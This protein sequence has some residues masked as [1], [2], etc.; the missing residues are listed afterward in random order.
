MPSITLNLPAAL[1]LFILFIAIGAV[2]VYYAL[3]QTGKV[4]DPTATATATATPTITVTPTPVTPTATNTPLPSPTPETY[5]VKAGDTCL[6]IAIAFNVSVNSI[7]LLNDLPA[8]CDTLFP[9]DKL[10][11]PQ[12]TPTVTPPA[13]ATMGPEEATRAACGEIEY[14]VQ[15][16]DTLSSIAANYAISITALKDYN[17]RVND[18]VRAG[19]TIKIPLCKRD[20]TPGPSP[21]PTL[22]PP[23]AAP[24]LLLPADGANFTQ[25][26]NTVTLQWAT[27]GTLRENEAYAVNILDA[28]TG[29]ERQ[30]E[31]VTDTKFIL[32]ASYRPTDNQ[33][34][35]IYWWVLTVRQT[36]SDKEGNPIW[37]P[38]GAASDR[39]GFT[40]VAGPSSQ[41]AETPTP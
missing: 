39:R 34:H 7:V 31:Y 28:T 12:P 37:E 1:G 26:D 11:I 10:M 3:Q 16:N 30:V 6:G 13:T 36:G 20:A 40:W 8:T 38:A 18:T 14:K 32:P 29:Q 35:L 4:V 27:V 9:G 5:T 19:E 24:N 21:T 41:P 22:P 25:A 17:G 2:F 33:V 15:E 23:Y